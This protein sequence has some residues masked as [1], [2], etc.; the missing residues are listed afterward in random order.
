MKTLYCIRH[1]FALHNKLFQYIGSQAYRKFRDTPLLYEGIIQAQNL[2]K[3][4]SD[5]DKVDLVVV[6]PCSRTLDTASHIFKAKKVPIIAKD[7]LIEY[8]LGIDICNR[9]RDIYYLKEQY[10]NIDF[11]YI[12]DNIFPWPHASKETILQLDTRIKEMFEWIG[13]RSEKNIAIISHSSFI[14]Q[15]KDG[16]MGNEE[17]ELK[18]C[19]P[20]K[21][22][23]NYD[24]KKKIFSYSS[25]NP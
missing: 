18:H 4:W 21:I 13:Q 7:F 6:S 20:Y 25:A 23:M 16:I 8:P 11:S 22:N 1:G 12:E 17:N 10:P 9:R 5:I 19:F 2:R 14:G 15:F 24:S 3:T